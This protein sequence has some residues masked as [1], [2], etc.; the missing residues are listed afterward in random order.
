MTAIIVTHNSQ[1]ELPRCLEALQNQTEPPDMVI[2]VD[3]GSADPRYLAPY[4]NQP[5]LRIIKKNNIGFG[6]GNNAGYREVPAESEHVLFLNPDVFLEKECLAQASK[7]LGKNQRVGML[8]GKLFRFDGPVGQS[9]WL[10]DSTG[11]FRSWYGRWHDRG[12]GQEDRGKYDEPDMD[13]PALC[14]AFLCCRRE[15]LEDCALERGII[16]DP[17]FFL[18][19]EDVELSLRMRKKGWQLMYQPSCRARHARGWKGKR[20]DIS[21]HFRKMA[22]WNEVTLYR[23]HPSPYIIWALGKYILVRFFNV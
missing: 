17:D 19:K 9:G 2:I 3:S 11:I 14:G 8:G 20:Q 22:A 6:A 13:V 4:E 15:A 1:E 21:I 18:Y 7:S 5:S 16:F 23:K 12:Q 10:L